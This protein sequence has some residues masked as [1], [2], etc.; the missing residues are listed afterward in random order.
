MEFAPQVVNAILEELAHAGEFR[1]EG[2]FEDGQGLA[3]V[4][5]F[6]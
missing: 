5:A 3:H 1:H 2:S 4:C 6:R